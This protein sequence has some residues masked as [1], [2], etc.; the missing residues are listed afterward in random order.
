MGI[1]S[2][3]LIFIIEKISKILGIKIPKF[4][5][6]SEIEGLEGKKVDSII[7]VCEKIGADEYISGPAAKDHMDH[8]EFQKFKQNNVD[9]SGLNS[10]I[11]FT[12][13]E[14]MNFYHIYLLL[15]SYLTQ[16]KK[17]ETI[18]E[19]GTILGGLNTL[20]IEDGTS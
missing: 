10:H 5:K 2:W 4:I 18:S 13:K 7:N 1:S 8:N 14:E 12:H 3:I 15:I 6:K 20:Q 17:Q 16:E 19:Q 9:L 11:H